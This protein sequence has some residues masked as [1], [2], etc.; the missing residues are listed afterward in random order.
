MKCNPPL[1]HLT[2][3]NEL[4]KRSMCLSLSGYYSSYSYD[5]VTGLDGDGM[6]EM[7]IV[8]HKSHVSLLPP[9][10]PPFKRWVVS[11]I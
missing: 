2:M 8:C 6:M 11:F 4:L 10:R 5:Y 1:P 3:T 7:M 9:P